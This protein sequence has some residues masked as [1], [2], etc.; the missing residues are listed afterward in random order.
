MI[1][2]GKQDINKEDIETVLETL[3]SDY[4]TQG[5]VV[6]KFEN[7]ISNFCKSSFAV[8]VT[9]ATAGL[10]LACMALGLKKGDLLW[11]SP[12]SFVASAIVLDIV[13][14]M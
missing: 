11:T 2:Y 12:I 7:D 9:S 8:A 10:H 5:P 14:Q 1:P 6:P 4:L 13:A 3:K